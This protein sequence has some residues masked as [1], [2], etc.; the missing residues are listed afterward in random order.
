MCECHCTDGLGLG[1]VD[2]NAYSA[3][4]ERKWSWVRLYMNRE[5]RDHACK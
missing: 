1:C 4:S 2:V 3:E 5:C